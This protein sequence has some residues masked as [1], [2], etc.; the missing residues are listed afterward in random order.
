M[1]VWYMDEKLKLIFGIET[2][3]AELEVYR[4]AVLGGQ[5]AEVLQ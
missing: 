1:G 3:A 2:E 4:T 5:G